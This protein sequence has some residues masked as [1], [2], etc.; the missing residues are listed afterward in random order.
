MA[1]HGFKRPNGWH[2]ETAGC[3]GTRKTPWEIS[4]A[5][6]QRY[7]DEVLTPVIAQRQGFA[8]RIEAG[9]EKELW[10]T[11]RKGS[12]KVTPDAITVAGR[13]FTGPN[14]EAETIEAFERDLQFKRYTEGWSKLTTWERACQLKIESIRAE[15]GQ[16][17]TEAKFQMRQIAGWTKKE[18]TPVAAEPASTLPFTPPGGV[19]IVREAPR[20]GM[21]GQTRY[22]VWDGKCW[23]RVSMMILKPMLADGTARW[24]T[25]TDD[26]KAASV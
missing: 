11:M 21:Y 23:Q 14:G 20:H 26:L 4:P 8:Q 18:L 16:I 5:A 1:K 22:E 9:T 13:E 12:I 3:W 19:A 10:F 25:T 24:R 15:A 2:S 17:E 7:L 6:A